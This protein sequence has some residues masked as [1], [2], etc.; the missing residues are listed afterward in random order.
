MI[1]IIILQLVL[2]VI[3]C[4]VICQRNIDLKHM[5]KTVKDAESQL[6]AARAIALDLTRSTEYYKQAYAGSERKRKELVA[7]LKEAEKK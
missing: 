7:R 1:E 5:D 2:I 3:L 4:L 6:D